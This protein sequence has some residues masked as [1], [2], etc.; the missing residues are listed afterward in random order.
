MI[1]RSAIL[2][3]SPLETDASTQMICVS[4]LRALT[5]ARGRALIRQ[6]QAHVIVQKLRLT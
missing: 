2:E 5:W 4:N 1:C 3:T 6:L